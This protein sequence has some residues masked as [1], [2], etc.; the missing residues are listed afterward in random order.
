M[1]G[2]RALALG[3]AGFALMAG[4]AVAADLIL[5]TP[6]VMD[7][8][9]IDWSGFYAGVGLTGINSSSIVEHIVSLDGIVGANAQSGQFV[10]GGEGYVSAKWTDFGGGSLYWGAGAEVRGGFLATEAVLL[11][12]ALGAE[13]ESGGN[14]YGTAGGG[15]EFMATSSVSVDLEY[16]H[17]FPLNN[18]WTG[19]SIGASVL[20]HF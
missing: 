20:W 19:D 7:T 1:V 6:P 11:Y 3:A 13:V 15:I 2:L 16:K 10:F 5:D 9:T 14:T 12:G 17:Y 8:A 4:S 18:A